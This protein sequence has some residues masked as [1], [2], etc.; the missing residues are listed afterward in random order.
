MTLPGD[1]RRADSG[2]VLPLILVYLLLS[3]LLVVAAADAAAVH[4]QRNRLA[5]IADAAALDAADALDAA[6]FYRSGAGQSDG[7]VPVTDQ[8]VLDSVSAF[9]VEAQVDAAVPG[10]AVATPTGSSDGHHVQVTLSA[11]AR[12]PILGPVVSSW[13]GDLQLTVTSRAGAVDLSVLPGLPADGQ[14]GP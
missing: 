3:T 13:T 7:V 14:P 5:S 1:C 12:L 8:S 2:Q 10:L 6:L 11:T 9:L 4:L